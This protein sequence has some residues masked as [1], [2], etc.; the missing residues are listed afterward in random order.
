MRVLKYLRFTRDYGL[1]YTRYHTVLEG[2]SDANW[3]SNV[4]DSK[5]Q[6]GYVFTLGGVAVSW[7]SL[8]QTIIARSTMKYEFITLDKCGEEVEWLCYFFEDIPRWP[9]PMPL[10]CVH[11]DIQSTIG[12]AQSSMYNGKSRH[13]C[14]RHNTIRQLISIGVISID[15]VKSKDNIADP[16]ANQVFISFQAQYCFHS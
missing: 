2:Y 11:C 5:S 3:I 16:L 15:H 1:H 12:R 14:R 6:S 4:K 8:K 13:I 7:K 10:I 9:N